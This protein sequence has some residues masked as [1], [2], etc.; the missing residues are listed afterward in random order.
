VF[1]SKLSK[2]FGLLSLRDEESLGYE[3]Q[4]VGMLFDGNWYR[5]QFRGSES[6]EATPLIHHYL[7]HGWTMGYS[8]HPLFDENWYKNQVGDEFVAR[9]GLIDYLERGSAEGLS[10][11]PLFDSSYYQSQSQD[12]LG[13]G[14]EDYLKRGHLRGFSPHPLFDE[15]WYKKVN[16][17]MIDPNVPG[18]LHYVEFGWKAGMSPHPLLG[19]A[20]IANLSGFVG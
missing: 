19:P 9:P 12:P 16:Y 4:I 11:H 7:L 15:K 17:E 2:L 1:R 20:Q 18:L 5:R 10:P 13:S 3:T 6:L 8:P 14:L